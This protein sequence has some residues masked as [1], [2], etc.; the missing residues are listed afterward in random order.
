MWSVPGQD[1]QQHLANLIAVQPSAPQSPPHHWSENKQDTL[2]FS[3][4]AESLCFSAVRAFISTLEVVES[5]VACQV[6]SEQ[7]PQP[8]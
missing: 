7:T 2:A 6:V 1:R 3:L 5:T 4:H 8:Y